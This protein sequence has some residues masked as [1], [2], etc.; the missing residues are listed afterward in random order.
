MALILEIIRWLIAVPAGL[1][2]VLCFL[3]NWSLLV[4]VLLRHLKSASLILPCIGP[5]F[6][7]VFFLAVPIDRLAAYWWIALIEP[8]SVVFL[9]LVAGLFMPQKQRTEIPGGN[10]QNNS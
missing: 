5:L 4:C 9:F 7:I 3:G 6:G 10:E 8:S 1:L 2:F